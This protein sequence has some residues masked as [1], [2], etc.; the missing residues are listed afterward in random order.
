M[1]TKYKHTVLSI[2]DK[3]TIYECLEKVSSKSKI[4]CEYKIT[5]FI[6]FM[7]IHLIIETF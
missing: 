6:Y 3:I 2:E 5:L 1:T 7:Y 4:A